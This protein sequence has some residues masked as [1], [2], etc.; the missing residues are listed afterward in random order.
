VTFRGVLEV[1]KKGGS[2]EGHARVIS[3]LAAIRRIIIY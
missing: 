3:V 2:R 1:R